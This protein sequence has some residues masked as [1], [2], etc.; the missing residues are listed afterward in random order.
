M[1]RRGEESPQSSPAA[2]HLRMLETARSIVLQAMSG[3]ISPARA[4]IAIR[5]VDQALDAAIG[6]PEQACKKGCCHCCHFVVQSSVAEVAQAVDYVQANFSEEQRGQLEDRL[7]QHERV[8]APWFGANLWEV[9]TKC[10]FLVDNLCSIYEARPLRCRGVNSLDASVCEQQKLHPER[11]IIPPRTPGQMEMARAAVQGVGDGLSKFAP[12]AARVDFARALGIA[13]YQ[14]GAIE[15]HFQG[16]NPFNPALVSY[17]VSKRPRLAGKELFDAKYGPGDEPVGRCTPTDLVTHFELFIEGDALGAVQALNGEHPVNLMRRIM[18]P[19]LYRSEDEVQ[20]WREHVQRSVRELGEAKFDPREAYDA[21][22]ALGT[23]EIAYQQYNDKDVLSELG[24]IVCHRITGKAL[25]DLCRP[26]EPRHR[27][28]KIKVGYISENLSFSNGGSWA[29]G[30]IQNHS[31]DIETWAISLSERPDYRTKQFFEA[32][33][34]F[35][36]F[37]DGSPANARAI[38]DLGLDVLIYRDLGMS[39][40]NY[41]YATMRLAP[42]QCTAWGHP[43]TSGLP[44]IDYYL[45]S[46]LMEPQ[47]GDSH[48]SEKL[49]R[50][51]GSGLCYTRNLNG[52]S[53]MF[54]SDFGLD[55]GLLYLSCQNPMKYLPRWDHLYAEICARTGRPIVFVEGPMPMAKDVL[56]ERMAAAGVKAVW[57]PGLGTS[58]FLALIKLADVFL[59]TPGWNGGNTTIEALSEGTPVVTLPGEFMRGRHSLAFCSVAGCPELV[60]SDVE[61][62]VDLAGDPSRLREVMKNANPD[63]LY[64]DTTPVRT[65][66]EF[67]RAAPQS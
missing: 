59:D 57:L 17:P 28:G 45:S 60:A 8:V 62:Y 25:P 7:F 27:G 10:P 3:G 5:Q 9:R 63:A 26:L 55:N 47:D 56:K 4:L 11:E 2:H 52:A 24:Q 20:W 19:M 48:Y 35:L 49:V 67:S 32:A 46:A 6:E 51:P 22:H 14:P 44:T 54:K 13:L 16:K 36:H 53:R 1:Q 33:D 30:W 64:G 34:H 43:V 65:L 58:D 66:D 50:L 42:V 41:Q 15:E 21:L 40:R 23:F 29:L 39:G 61:G 18:V 12:G 37:T 31:E 38:K